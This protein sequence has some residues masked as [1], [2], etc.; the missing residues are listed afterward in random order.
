MITNYN[1]YSLQ[2]KAIFIT[3]A[4]SGIGR[5]IAIECSK[6]GAHLYITGRNAE[7]L[8]ETMESLKGDSHLMYIGD[9]TQETDIIRIVSEL[10]KLDGIVM[11]A[12]VNDKSLIKHLNAA[13]IEKVIGTNFTSPA[14][15]LK[16]LTKQ[17]KLNDNSSVVMI[18][19]ISSSYATVSNTLY[20]ASK[21]AIE[22]MIRV[23]AL[24]LS[25]KRIRVNGIRPGV[26]DTPILNSYALKENLE[27]F[28]KQIPLGRIGT[29]EDIAHAAIYLLS[30]AS[31]WVTGNEITIDG[32][33]TL[34]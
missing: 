12:G 33:I 15:T 11:S 31:S 16:E 23:A 27:D 24:E 2:G 8:Q 28:C 22:S 13:K 17:K 5:D 34:R 4:S 19:S 20:A 25:S 30:D 6:M 1:P 32:G 10:P 14:L 3:G 9:L 7:R 26:V 29:P 18:S 21:A